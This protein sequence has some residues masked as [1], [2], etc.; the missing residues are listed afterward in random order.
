MYSCSL[1][2][3]THTHTHTQ[4]DRLNEFVNQQLLDKERPTD[5]VVRGP[6]AGALSFVLVIAAFI[7]KVA[8]ILK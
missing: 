6:L 5:S 3:H 1:H 7:F 4:V 8:S 2:T